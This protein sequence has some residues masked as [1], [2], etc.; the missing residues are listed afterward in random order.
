MRSFIYCS[1]MGQCLLVKYQETVVSLWLFISGYVT[2]D[3]Q[4]VGVMQILSDRT[5]RMSGPYNLDT[6]VR[7]N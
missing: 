1:Y 7:A 4:E 5:Y 6:E 3:F 2:A